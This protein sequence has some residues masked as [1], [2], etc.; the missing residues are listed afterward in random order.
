MPPGH[1]G[2][3]P[4]AGLRIEQ[5]IRPRALGQFRKPPPGSPDRASSV[6][7]RGGQRLSPC[8]Q[9]QRLQPQLRP[10]ARGLHIPTDV[11]QAETPFHIRHWHGPPASA[12]AASHLGRDLLSQSRG[13]NPFLPPRPRICA[14]SRTPR[15][16]GLSSATRRSPTCAPARVTAGPS[17]RPVTVSPAS[18]PR[19]WTVPSDDPVR[20]PRRRPPV[21]FSIISSSVSRP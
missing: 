21:P 4:A 19:P 3:Q 2:Q 1:R 6:C 8:Q 9:R 18:S 15:A 12:R 20:L 14:A 7:P 5:Q 13:D 17:S 16:Q 11:P 10:H